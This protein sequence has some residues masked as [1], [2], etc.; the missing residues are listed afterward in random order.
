MVEGDVLV[1]SLSVVVNSNAKSQT[2]TSL[3][4]ELEGALDEL[5]GK[6]S[7]IVSDDVLLERRQMLGNHAV[8]VVV[9]LPHLKKS[10]TEV[11]KVNIR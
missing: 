7:Q 3:A 4:N 10:I 2:R 11:N 5:G 6:L 8:N 9:L 1:L